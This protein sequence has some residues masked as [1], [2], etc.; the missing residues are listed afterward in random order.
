[1]NGRAGGFTLIELLV[2]VVLGALAIGAAY[3]TLTL[4]ERAS[5]HQNAIITTLETNRTAIDVL[6]AELRE[7]SAADGDLLMAAPE[8]LTFRAFRKAG[9]VCQVDALGLDVWLL[10]DAPFA[11]GDRV[12]VFQ[13]FDPAAADDDAWSG[14]AV[15]IGVGP[16]AGGCTAWSKP[17]ARLSLAG[18][19]VGPTNISPGAPI[20]SY[21]VL[22]YGHYQI[23][24]EWSLGQRVQ[25]RPV[26]A[27][28]GPLAPPEQRGLVFRYYDESGTALPA[29]LAAA[30]RQR[31]ARIEVKVR[32]A[33]PGAVVGS[34]NGTYVDSLVM[35]IN[36][37]GN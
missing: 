8:S 26:V 5:R 14:P 12:L 32:A 4:Q 15:V 19:A 9:I 33:T 22:T 11:V 21:E 7:I 10:S 31:V 17:T 28:V 13:D 37:R 18:L 23:G 1:M 30:D 6:A 34:G 27:L 25:G 16:A 2:V 29:P 20:R 36:L 35:Q 24:G 3:Q